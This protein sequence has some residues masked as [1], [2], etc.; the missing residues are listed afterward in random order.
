MNIL[1]VSDNTNGKLMPA[2]PQPTCPVCTALECQTPVAAVRSGWQRRNIRYS[3]AGAFC[4]RLYN[5]GKIEIF[6]LICSGFGDKLI[7]WSFNVICGRTRFV[8]ALSSAMHK[9]VSSEPV[10]GI[11]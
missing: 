11:L 4:I 1:A 9:V 2:I 5:C 6:L 8:N 7:F 10:Y 3:L